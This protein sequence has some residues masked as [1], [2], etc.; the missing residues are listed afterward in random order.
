MR[1]I[2]VGKD[3][4]A[5]TFGLLSSAQGVGVGIES[6]TTIVNNARLLSLQV[7]TLARLTLFAGVTNVLHTVTASPVKDY[8][9][10][11]PFF[12]TL[13]GVLGLGC[14]GVGG[15]I[16]LETFILLSSSSVNAIS[17]QPA[18]L[19]GVLLMIFGTFASWNSVVGIKRHLHGVATLS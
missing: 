1:C 10:H 2:V 16:M 3:I 11:H 13:S 6:S 18:V 15:M 14:L 9:R 8:L 12:A 17:N 7:A 19:G 4:I 5:L